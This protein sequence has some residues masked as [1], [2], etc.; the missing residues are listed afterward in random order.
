M[1]TAGGFASAF[2]SGVPGVP[3]VL[4]LHPS[5]RRPLFRAVRAVQA[6]SRAEQCVRW[7]CFRAEQ[8]VRRS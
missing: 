8:R 3:G 6:S 2:A 7:M 4:S 5:R 1:S